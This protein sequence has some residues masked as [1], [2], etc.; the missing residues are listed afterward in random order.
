M[1]NCGAGHRTF[2]L[3]PTGKVRPCP[4]LP[5]S[6][7]VIGDLTQQNPIDVFSAPAVTQLKDLQSPNAQTCSGCNLEYYCRYCHTR[8][9]MKQE[10][11]D[12]L[13]RWISENRLEQY[14]NFPSMGESINKKRCAANQKCFS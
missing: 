12:N 10:D 7:L 4:V 13:C 6:Y 11:R 3:G 2:V 8:A 5:E 14:V 1:N 9:I